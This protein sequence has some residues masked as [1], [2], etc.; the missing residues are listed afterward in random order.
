MPK[1]ILFAIPT[2]T[3]GGAERVMT[4]LVNYSVNAGYDVM[5]VNFDKDSSFYPLNPKVYV[6]KLDI[7][8]CGEQ[9]FRKQ[10]IAPIVELK[11][12]LA[13]RRLIKE[14]KPNLIIAFLKTSEILFGINALM[15]HIPF[16][17]S[18]R[19]DIGAYK[20]VLNLFRKFAYPKADLIVC[21]TKAVEKSLRQ[22]INCKTI[23]LPNPIASTAV[24]KEN[25]INKERDRRIIA[26]GR[27]CEQKNFEL[28][29]RTMKDVYSKNPD[30]CGYNVEI[31][32]EGA[33]R[34]KLQSLVD[35]LKVSQVKLCGIVPNA[36]A[37]NNSAA[38]YIM[39][40]NF[41][42]FPN[43]LVE[44]MA[45]GIPSISTNFP[46]G[47]AEELIGSDNECGMLIPVGDANALENAIIYML[48]HNKEAEEKAT[49]ALER[50]SEFD[51]DFVCK[52]WMHYADE[53]IES[54]Q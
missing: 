12:F 20:G 42:G 10:I 46:S 43:T 14:E 51:C 11:R 27:L 37:A 50:V 30:L 49:H 39:S 26:V 44:A 5:F 47:A 22:W 33:D 18:I 17:T 52:K 7:G 6:K 38:L 53:I 40:S 2:N 23:V 15:L 29:I 48:R 13:V 34:S 8:F 9:G 35:E 1:K 45:N 21:Q 31:F 4:S 36:L 16:V 24:N 3:S 19:N 41:E 25:Y 28:L 54:R 32:G